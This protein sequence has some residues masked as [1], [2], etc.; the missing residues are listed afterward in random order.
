MR[1][2]DVPWYDNA[3]TDHDDGMHTEQH[4]HRTAHALPP[5][6][7]VLLLSVLSSPLPVCDGGAV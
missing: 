6:G 3:L 5:R 2:S 1:L 4:T 7:T